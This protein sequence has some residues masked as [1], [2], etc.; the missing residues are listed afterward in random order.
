MYDDDY[1]VDD[2]NVKR[3]KELY[4]QDTVYPLNHLQLEADED[5]EKEVNDKI[6]CEYIYEYVKCLSSQEQQIFNLHFVE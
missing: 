3:D 6:T 4:P 1:D 2:D 5:I